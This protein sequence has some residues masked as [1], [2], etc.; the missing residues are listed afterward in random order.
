MRTHILFHSSEHLSCRWAPGDWRA[1]GINARKT[2]Y[3][4]CSYCICRLCTSQDR[5][6]MPW[7]TLYPFILTA[8]KPFINQWAPGFP[9]TKRVAFLWGS[10]PP[11]FHRYH[12][13][14]KLS[15]YLGEQGERRIKFI[16]LFF[17][18]S[19]FQNP[20]K[21]LKEVKRFFCWFFFHLF[22]FH[23][24]QKQEDVTIFT[25]SKRLEVHKVAWLKILL[26]C[27]IE[28]WWVETTVYRWHLNIV[29]FLFLTCLIYSKKKYKQ[30]K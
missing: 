14:G 15:I 12:H 20:Y 8:A 26:R 10:E 4:Q 28:G 5:R 29:F 13:C 30:S 25:P 7:C 3:I 16:D 23:G 17:I 27:D 19:S 2:D 22:V 1:L 11:L 21:R 24:G 6:S 18:M 9:P